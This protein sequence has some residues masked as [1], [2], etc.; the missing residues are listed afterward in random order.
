MTEVEP[1]AD[2]RLELAGP[3][4]VLSDDPRLDEEAGMPNGGGTLTEVSLADDS[5]AVDPTDMSLSA[6]WQRLMAF[7]CTPRFRFFLTLFGAFLM[8]GMVSE[9]RRARPQHLLL[10]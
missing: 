4:L 3:A 6:R 8:M 5:A 1:I 9:R 10:T 7:V 2:P